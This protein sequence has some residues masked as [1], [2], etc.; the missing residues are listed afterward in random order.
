MYRVIHLCCTIVVCSFRLFESLSLSSLYSSGWIQHISDK[1]MLNGLY[2]FKGVLSIV[3]AIFPI[4]TALS[5]F[6]HLLGCHSYNL[7]VYSRSLQLFLKYAVRAFV[8][9]VK[10]RCLSNITKKCSPGSMPL[11]NSFREEGSSKAWKLVALSI[12]QLVSLKQRSIFILLSNLSSAWKVNAAFWLPLDRFQE[13][14]CFP[15]FSILV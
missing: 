6:Q 5:I 15:C 11:A 2:W 4:H 9:L 12:F 3:P 10:C 8:L 7:G 14:H 13:Q 1:C